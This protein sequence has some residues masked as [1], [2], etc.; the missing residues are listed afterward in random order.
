MFCKELLMQSLKSELFYIYYT[1]I[2]YLTIHACPAD[3]P[4]RQYI[5]LENGSPIRERV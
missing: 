2:V 5:S 3:S 4:M 1:G